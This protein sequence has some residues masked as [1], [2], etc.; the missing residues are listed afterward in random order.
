MLKKSRRLSTKQFDEVMKKGRVVH[1]SLFLMRFMNDQKDTRISAVAPVK[2]FKKAVLR[3]ATRRKMYIIIESV[4]PH[5]KNG[6]H[7]A[8]FPKKDIS[9]IET[10]DLTRDIQKL[11]Q[12]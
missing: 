10:P 7:G 5:V 3:N 8:V 4:W 6:I 9:G 11:F 12:G 1:S 2:I